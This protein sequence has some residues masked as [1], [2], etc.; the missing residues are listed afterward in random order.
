M[1]GLRLG[2]T[3]GMRVALSIVFFL[4][5]GAACIGMNCFGCLASGYKLNLH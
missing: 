5:L 3:P 2:R 1:L 4:V